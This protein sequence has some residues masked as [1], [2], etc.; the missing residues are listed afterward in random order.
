MDCVVKHVEL[1]DAEP[2]MPTPYGRYVL[3]MLAVGEPVLSGM[4]LSD[5]M[6]AS[7]RKCRDC[8]EAVAMAR[9]IRDAHASGPIILPTVDELLAATH[10][11]YSE[12]VAYPNRLA[13][14]LQMLIFLWCGGDWQRDSYFWVTLEAARRRAA[15]ATLRRSRQ[16]RCMAV[17]AVLRANS[18]PPIMLPMPPAPARGRGRG[19]ASAATA[20]PAGPRQM[21]EEGARQVQEQLGFLVRHGRVVADEA[22]AALVL[23][24]PLETCLGKRKCDGHEEDV[25]GSDVQHGRRV[26]AK[27]QGGGTRHGEKPDEADDEKE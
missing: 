27:A 22:G 7:R 15:A 12:F 4:T 10:Q 23:T 9:A 11:S 5:N 2:H 25:H 18:A 24:S 3:N 17:A 16:A 14:L 1:V 6:V 21:D 20:T 8:P 13:I 26:R 19:G